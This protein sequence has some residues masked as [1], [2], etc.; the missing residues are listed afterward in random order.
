MTKEFRALEARRADLA[1]RQEALLSQVGDMDPDMA[2]RAL[3]VMADEVDAIE[4]EYATHLAALRSQKGKRVRDGRPIV[5][6]RLEPDVMALLAARVEKVNGRAGG[7][8]LYVRR[9]IY[10]H[11]GLPLPVQHGDL[12]RSSAKRKP[13]GKPGGWPKGKPRKPRADGQG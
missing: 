3:N 13:T 7:I 10:E 8:A 5:G 6:V 1:A 12:G 2:A 9:L 4:A 11:L